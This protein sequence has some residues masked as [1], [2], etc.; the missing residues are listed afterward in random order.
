MEIGVSL[1]LIADII[2][3]EVLAY[4]M[5]QYCK[6][7]TPISFLHNVLF[8]ERW[9]PCIYDQAKQSYFDINRS[10]F[11]LSIRLLRNYGLIALEL[12]F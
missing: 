9:P 5:C 1:S 6:G 2:I 4:K 3:Y 8:H 10:A 7:Y 12:F 11:Y